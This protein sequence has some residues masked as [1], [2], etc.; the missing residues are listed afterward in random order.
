MEMDDDIYLGVLNSKNDLDNNLFLNQFIIDDENDLNIF[1]GI[2]LSSKYFNLKSFSAKC[3]SENKPVVISLNI[4]SL[5]SKF[6]DLVA[7]ISNLNSKNIFIDVIA[8]QETWAVP[9]PE[10]VSSPGYQKLYLTA[11]KL[12]GV[13]VWVSM[14]VTILN[15]KCKKIY[16]LFVKIFL[17]AFQFE[18][19]ST[20][21]NIFSPMYTDPLTP[22]PTYPI[23]M[24]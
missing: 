14:Y 23:L 1:N 8:L 5:Q 21:R 19:N 17:N 20:K 2:L 16:L 12:A 4:Q 9:Y 18:L 7:F 22:L 10:A 11:G 13:G 15:L 6:N 3:K 24:P